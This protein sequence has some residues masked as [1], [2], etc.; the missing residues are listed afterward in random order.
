[1]GSNWVE[2]LLEEYPELYDVLDCNT[3][4]VRVILDKAILD[5]NDVK[6]IKVEDSVLII[7]DYNVGYTSSVNKIITK[8]KFEEYSNFN[9]EVLLHETSQ[10]ISTKEELYVECSYYPNM[11]LKGKVNG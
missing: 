7:D 9:S 1:M 10:L 2:C 8:H 5:F 11:K 6:E 4:D 3:L